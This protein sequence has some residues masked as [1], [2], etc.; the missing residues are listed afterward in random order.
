M[1]RLMIQAARIC[2]GWYVI[3]ILNFYSRSNKEIGSLYAL[4]ILASS[5]SIHKFKNLPT[6]TVKEICEVLKMRQS[7]VA[8]DY[9]CCSSCLTL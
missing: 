4:T 3:Y 1:E 8:T 7:V 9:K 2:R 5:G 6:S